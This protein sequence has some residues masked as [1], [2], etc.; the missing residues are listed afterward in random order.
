VP[1]NSRLD[2]ELGIIEVELYGEL[3]NEEVLKGIA[4]VQRMSKKEGVNKVLVDATRVETAPSTG[5]TFWI[6]SSSPSVFRQAVLIHKSQTIS[7][8]AAFIEDV[9]Y[10]SG[11]ATRVFDNREDALNW[12]FEV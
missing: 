10:N 7:A 12:L 4:E 5:E 1:H 3:D 6:F 11:R 9:S 2:E 8:D